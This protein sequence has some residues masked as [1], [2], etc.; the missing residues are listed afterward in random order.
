[1]AADKQQIR[2]LLEEVFECTD[3][4]KSGFIDQ[5]EL[6]NVI[7]A[8]V[9]HPDCPEEHKAAHGSPEKIKECC[10][11]CMQRPIQPVSL[12]VSVYV[13]AQKV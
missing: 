6:E 1:M 3:R 4:D 9:E 2:Q 10:E 8:Y 5:A 7:R 11:V 13:V 12:S